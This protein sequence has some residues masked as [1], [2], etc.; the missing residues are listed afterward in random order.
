LFKIWQVLLEPR[1]ALKR[2]KARYWAF[3]PLPRIFNRYSQE[4]HAQTQGI[5]YAKNA[6]LRATSCQQTELQ[7]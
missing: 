2:R 3:I 4:C 7:G 6:R 5:I 1:H